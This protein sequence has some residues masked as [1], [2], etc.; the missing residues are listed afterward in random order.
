MTNE[1]PRRK[2]REAPSERSKPTSDDDLDPEL[3]D[4]LPGWV[5]VFRDLRREAERD[6]STQSGP[7]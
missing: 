2:R 1:A 4:R 6:E 7:S 5:R 3:V